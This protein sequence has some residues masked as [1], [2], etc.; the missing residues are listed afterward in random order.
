MEPHQEGGEAGKTAHIQPA[1]CGGRDTMGSGVRCPHAARSVYGV[2][3]RLS[4]RMF[5]RRRRHL[6]RAMLWHGFECRNHFLQVLGIRLE[7]CADC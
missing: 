4:R 2:A 3:R 5:S 1:R 7:R 6:G